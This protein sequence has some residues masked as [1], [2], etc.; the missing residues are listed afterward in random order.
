MNPEKRPLPAEVLPFG[1]EGSPLRLEPL[2]AEEE[3]LQSQEDPFVPLSD[4][5]RF[6]R[7]L[8]GRIAAGERTLLPVALKIQRSTCRP[9]AAGPHKDVP[10]NPQRDRRWRREREILNLCAGTDVVSLIDLGDPVLH[11][12]PVTLC[13]R[14]RAYFHPAC[15]RCRTLL[16]DCR[17]DALLR[18][19]GLPEY[20]SSA[21]RYL[22]C[23]ACTRSG[24]S[25]QVFYTAAPA[26]E[27]RPKGTVQVRRR[28]ELYRD[29]GALLRERLPEEERRRLAGIFPCLDCPHREE[30]YP[31]S[32]AAGEPLPAETR[33]VPLSFH[34]FYLFPLE[35]CELHYDEFADLLG[36]A[37]WEEVRARARRR[38]GAG[39][40]P[41]LSGLDALFA[42]PRQWLFRGDGSGRFPLEVLR[43][44]LALFGRLV[45]AVRD[46]HARAR[47]PHLGLE[48]DHVMVRPGGL[49]EGLPQRWGFR[50]KLCGAAGARRFSAEGGPELLE[51]DPD[52]DPLFLSPFLREVEFGR[53][54]TMR[55]AVQSV[56]AEG[57]RVRLEGTA[58]S[59]RVRLEAFQP[60]D[61][62]RVI[63]VNAG[64]G[65]EHL[66]FWGSLGERTEGGLRFTAVLEEG[67]IASPSSIRIQEFDAGVAFYRRFHA[68]CDLYPLGLLL[69]RTILVNDA[70]DLFA[71]EAAFQRVLK[72]LTLR[73][74]ERG[75]A[76]APRVAAALREFLEAEEE[77]FGPAALLYRREERDGAKAAL[78]GRLWLDLL[79]LG[80]RLATAVPGFS[81]CAHHADVPADRPEEALD[82]VLAE[83][84]ELEARADVELFGRAVRDGEIH[85]V[86]R[87]LLGEM[88]GLS[89]P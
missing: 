29:L 82:R 59:E 13:R 69:F 78:P 18:D 64:G 60:G 55:I 84:G 85:E 17:D 72:K 51:P 44:K 80:F 32:A 65:L 62:I 87:E 28:P 23:P 88:S 86:C 76:A 50:V 67:R 89:G 66:T 4:T 83:L 56:Q 71:V 6:S 36:G 57:P 31:S 10:S 41:L 3:I 5:G 34:E 68:P 19:C 52:A 46:Y 20:G 27:E 24:V 74:E 70:R 53:E 21:V 40:E 22:H 26:G 75:T 63:P 25:P 30:C 81:F 58:S 42:S 14:R 43:L 16:E 7:V 49:P 33:L 8:L 9:S 15:P 37:S 61:V 12:R 2:L 77:V 1:P 35:A 39:R 45:R 47:E 38:G 73:L 11:S 54:E 79:T 48:P